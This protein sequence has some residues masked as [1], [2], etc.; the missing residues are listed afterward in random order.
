MGIGVREQGTEGWRG[1]LT[2]TVWV[3]MPRKEAVL[4][5][6]RATDSRGEA[7]AGKKSD[8]KR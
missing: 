8:W 2:E 3:Y 1:V 4:S 6:C 7:C 5:V